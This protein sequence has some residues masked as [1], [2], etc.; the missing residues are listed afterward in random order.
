MLPYFLTSSV[1]AFSAL[2]LLTEQQEGHPAC[3][4][5][6]VGVLAWLSVWSEVQTCIWP[7]WCYRHSLSLAPVKTRLVLPFWYRL[8]RVV[9]GKGPLNGCSLSLYCLLFW[10][11]NVYINWLRCAAVSSATR[12]G[13]MSSQT[14]TL[15]STW[16]HCSWSLASD[17]PPTLL[18]R[19]LARNVLFTCLL[20]STEWPVGK[21]Q[22]V[23]CR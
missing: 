13:L 14:S 17:S 7:S 11:I 4:K 9:L 23:F 15:V 6:S 5:L 19:E 22:T 16:R 1:L 2:T 12:K 8:T 10:W 3:K 18:C 21:S 20:I